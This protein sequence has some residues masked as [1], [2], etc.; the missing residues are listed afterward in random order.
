MSTDPTP[1]SKLIELLDL[2]AI[3]KNIFR[4]RQPHESLQRVF[5]GQVLGQGDAVQ[6]GYLAV[7]CLAAALA[8]AIV[9][10]LRRRLGAACRRLWRILNSETVIPL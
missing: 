5:G 1:L 3:D 2:E 6:F 9:A 4:G 8:L 10:S 7:F